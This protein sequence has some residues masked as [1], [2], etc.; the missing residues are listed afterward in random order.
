MWLLD[1]TVLQK[2]CFRSKCTPSQSTFG[3]WVVSWQRCLMESRYSQERTS[4]FYFN[5][6]SQLSQS[7]NN[8][9]HPPALRELALYM[10]LEL[11]LTSHNQLELILNV[12]GTPT[13]DEFYAITSRRSKE[14]IRSLQFRTKKSF[15]SIYPKASDHAIDFL[16]KT[17]TCE[18]PSKF[19]FPVPR[20]PYASW[21]LIS[22][23]SPCT[24]LC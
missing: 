4:T 19:Q 3:Q 24:Y 5:F 21:H 22:F 2:S 20:F 17:L 23:L 10:L 15:R 1:G 9:H 6:I 12:L 8:H 16:E 14:Y 11:T 13:I 18:S 7:H